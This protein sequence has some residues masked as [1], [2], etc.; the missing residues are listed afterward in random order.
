MPSNLAEAMIR[1]LDDSANEGLQLLN[2]AL[3]NS[4]HVLGR[5]WTEQLSPADE[6]ALRAIHKILPG[7]DSHFRT[8][9]PSEQAQLPTKV[10]ATLL[11][12]SAINFSRSLIRLAW[13]LQHVETLLPMAGEIQ[14]ELNSHTAGVSDIHAWGLMLPSSSRVSPVTYQSVGAVRYPDLCKFMRNRWELGSFA[15][16]GISQKPLGYQFIL[17]DTNAKIN[18][19]V[20]AD[21]ETLV[22]Q[23]LSEFPY[24]TGFADGLFVM[25]TAT[26]HKNNLNRSTL[27][28][29]YARTLRV[30]TIANS[31]GGTAAV[32]MVAQPSTGFL[33]V[34]Y[35]P[36]GS[37]TED[38]EDCLGRI[39]VGLTRSKSLTLVVSPLDMMGL[40]GM[41]Q[42]LATLAYGVQGLRRGFTTWDWPSFDTNPVQE[43]NSQME[44][45]SL[46]E[47]PSWSF[48]PLAIANQYHDQRSSQPLNVRYRLILVKAS[49]LDWLQKDRHFLRSLHQIAAA[50]HKWIPVQNLPFDELI[51]F[52][53]AA[54]RTPRPTYV[55]LPSGL[56]HARTGRVLPQTGPSQEITPLPGIY[57]F[58]GWRMQPTLDIP[59]NLP[60]TKEAPTYGGGTT[61]HTP[62]GTEPTRSPEEEARDILATAAKN[63]PEDGPSTRRAAI[64]AC[65]YL[66]TIVSQHGP[67]LQAVY[68]AAKV[69]AQRS[70]GSA[71]TD[72]TQYRPKESELPVIAPELTSEL[73]HCL[74]TLPDPWP[75]AKIT[76]NMD[77]ASQWVSRIR[78]LFFADEYTRHTEGT[79]S[80]SQTPNMESAFQAVQNALPKLENRVIEFLAEWLVALLAPARHVLETRSPHLSFML[81]KEYWFR[82]LYLGLKVTAS[83]DRTESYV[84]IIDGQVRCI[85]PDF[86]PKD[87]HVAWNVQYVV[88]FVPAWMLPPMYHSLRRE[89]V[90]STDSGSVTGV[91]SIRPTWFQDTTATKGPP[92][93]S[94]QGT[95]EP[96]RGLRLTIK[97]EVL[98]TSDQPFFPAVTEL[99]K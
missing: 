68:Y 55:Y 20:A 72:T 48:P 38:T 44:R 98:V 16:G 46:H 69:H 19:L 33:N 39:T 27:K 80:A 92:P 29:D 83:F 58:D 35:Q 70:R 93:S 74:S 99:A 57:F 3:R 30:E 6:E 31:A 90:K 51:L 60:S 12:G 54:D 5:V 21:L 76:I 97:E 28:K 62:R 17:W 9:L 47:A 86:K 41:A 34:R 11:E 59:S 13:M 15:S 22:S 67:Q 96:M 7:L 75:L 42:V 52:A 32:A 56:Y 53:Y 89:S 43:N 8:A 49:D 45:W 26:D 14:P 24:N 25:T 4:E 91:K 66:R 81:L 1:L 36:D 63:Q 78:R 65:K 87:L 10:D 79:P 40:I 77:S 71:T 61:M 88:V 50:G 18:G 64:R 73:L 95:L 2:Q 37:P 23:V 82:E 94:G 85:T 84:R